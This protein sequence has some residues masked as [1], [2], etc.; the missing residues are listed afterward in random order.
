MP[1][2]LFLNI[3]VFVADYEHAHPGILI[4]VRY[5]VCISA[6]PVLCFL[7]FRLLWGK[8][9]QSPKETVSEVTYSSEIQLVA[10]SVFFLL[11]VSQQ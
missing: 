2:N 3:K 8:Q 9:R 6:W 5:F 7:H 10:N 4:S 1:Y 11:Q